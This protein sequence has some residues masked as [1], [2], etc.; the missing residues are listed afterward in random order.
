MCAERA[1]GVG[2]SSTAGPYE[3][4]R[5]GQDRKVR[6]C[7]ER[8]RKRLGES[9][10]TTRRRPLRFAVL[11]R[12]LVR[13]RFACVRENAHYETPVGRARACR[14]R[15]RALEYDRVLCTFIRPVL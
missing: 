4:V 7:C 8:N 5:K 14:S 10:L 1:A 3:E 13:A 6:R 12:R 15:R 2:R 9:C 11:A